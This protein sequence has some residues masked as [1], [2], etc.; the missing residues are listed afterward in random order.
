MTWT[1][2][3]PRPEPRDTVGVSRAIAALCTQQIKRAERRLWDV[4]AA[5]ALGVALGVLL[6]VAAS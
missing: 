3:H 5:V 4:V 1:A 6:V 2:H